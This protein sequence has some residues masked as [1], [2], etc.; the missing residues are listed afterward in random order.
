MQRLQLIKYTR[1][2]EEQD[3][4]C[5]ILRCSPMERQTRQKQQVFLLTIRNLH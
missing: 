3:R 5:G 2:Y 1:S 4:F